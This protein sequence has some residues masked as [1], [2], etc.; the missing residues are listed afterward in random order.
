MARIYG[1]HHHVDS[2]PLRITSWI[3]IHLSWMCHC[4]HSVHPI[5][6]LTGG[7]RTLQERKRGTGVLCAAWD[8]GDVSIMPRFSIL[9]P[10]PL[11]WLLRGQP[12]RSK[13]SPNLRDSRVCNTV[14]ICIRPRILVPGQ[15][16]PPDYRSAPTRGADDDSQTLSR[17]ANHD[18]PSGFRLARNK[19]PSS[20]PSL[21]HH[22]LLHLFSCLR[23]SLIFLICPNPPRRRPS[24]AAPSRPARV[25]VCQCQWLSQRSP[26]TPT[27]GSS[28]THKRIVAG[29]DG[30]RAVHRALIR[31]SLCPPLPFLRQS[32]SNDVGDTTIHETDNAVDL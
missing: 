20:P 24:C 2:C 5:H 17:P 31:A 14:I 19:P 11:L 28:S 4:L 15:L 13:Q 7:V 27:P 32:D 3:G 29:C 1:V 6:R 23:Y 8:G 21:L 10:F 25:S 26:S 18:A 30:R 22:L 16:L 12:D 9:A